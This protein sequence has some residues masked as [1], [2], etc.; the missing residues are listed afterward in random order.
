MPQLISRHLFGDLAVRYVQPTDTTRC[1]LLLVPVAAEHLLAEPRTT[2][3]SRLEIANLPAKLLPL[4]PESPNSLVQLKLR[5][6]P[7]G[8]GFASGITMM[9]SRTMDGLNFAD[10]RVDTA[11]DVTTILTTLADRD[12][13]FRC[14]HHLSHRLGEAGVQS[15]VTFHNDSPEPLTL[16]MLSSF[17]LNG[18]TPFVEADSTPHLRFHRFRSW[19]SLEG[20]VE[21]TTLRDLHLERSWTGLVTF[22]ERFGQVGSMPARKWSPTAAVEDT[23][24]GVT[25]AA[26]LAW[27]GSWQMELFRQGDRVHLAG[28][29]A[30][31]DTGHWM[32]TVAPGESFTTPPATLTAV[33]GNLDDACHALLDHQ[34]AALAALPAAEADLPIVFNEWCTS[35]GNPTHDNL[36]A[37]ARRLRGTGVRVIV[38]DDG[39]AERPP[40]AVLQSNGDWR[41]DREKFPDGLAATCQALRDLGFIPGIWFEF[42]VVNPASDQWREESHL[43]QRD[44]ATLEVG[45]R[46]FWNLDDPW[47]YDFLTRKMIHLLR[48]CG[49]GYLKVDYNDSIGLGCDHPDSLGEGLRLHVEGIH[50]F[51]RHLR[52][53]LP[54]LVIENCSSGGHRLEP[55]M[56]ALCS[57][58]S[59]SDAHEGVVIPII[60]RNLQRL[61]LPRQCLIWAVLRAADDVTRVHYS[62]TATFLGRMCLSGE[63]HELADWQM[64]IIHEATALY[65]EVAPI[66]RDGTSTFYGDEN[67]SYVDPVGWQVVVRTLGRSTLV[68]AH[69]FDLAEPLTV[70][71]PL[72]TTP[73]DCRVVKSFHAE[74]N[75]LRIGERAGMI[76]VLAQGF[77]GAVWLLEAPGPG[78]AI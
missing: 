27:S 5:S 33:R 37:I 14:V 20:K 74:R 65:A 68:V 13:R 36:L 21:T 54:D 2:L 48:D 35:W 57:L 23:T 69:G 3:E 34:R 39:W 29:L 16:E 64:A 18:I 52:T 43:L 47:V 28:G 51:F 4:P 44:G 11:D 60:A 75:S 12:G 73:C 45:S 62:L 49:F 30:D 50:R 71:L 56:Q 66:I 76:L 1:E 22:S 9:H 24:H 25:W 78:P 10:Q 31:R 26:Q 19:W 46:R 41:V 38:I 72:A 40:D 77:Q 55:A 58:G 59:F 53:E 32:K 17:L 42:E 7:S 15:W 67:I 63:I 70:S 61:I 6:D 8:P